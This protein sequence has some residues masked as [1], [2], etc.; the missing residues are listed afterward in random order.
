MMKVTRI[1]MEDIDD[2]VVMSR[3]QIEA[4]VSHLVYEERVVRHY[5]K[6]FVQNKKSDDR[7]YIARENGVAVGYLVAYKRSYLF[8]YGCFVGQ[9]VVWVEPEHRG[10]KAFIALMKALDDM[11]VEHNA[12]ECYAGVSNGVSIDKLLQWFKRKNFT[13]VGYYV[14][15]IYT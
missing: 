2:L 1:E 12:K 14:K 11:A 9:E 10:G 6:W 7:V 15:K 8:N 5:A 13:K 4:T 3:N